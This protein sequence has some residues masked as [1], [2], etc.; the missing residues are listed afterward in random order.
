MDNEICGFGDQ[1]IPAD[2]QT[3][4]NIGRDGQKLS[5]LRLA[6]EDFKCYGSIGGDGFCMDGVDPG[7]RGA[8]DWLIFQGIV[9]CFVDPH[10]AHF[11]S[12]EVFHPTC[13]GKLDG[14]VINKRTKTDT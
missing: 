8:V 1:T 14:K 12:A 6:G 4:G 7:K 10:L 11:H 9:K 2:N 5:R 13:E 3:N